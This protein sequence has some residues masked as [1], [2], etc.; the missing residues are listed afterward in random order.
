MRRL[1]GCL[2]P[3]LRIDDLQ[4]GSVALGLEAER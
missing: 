4:A 2:Q 3:Q 1:L